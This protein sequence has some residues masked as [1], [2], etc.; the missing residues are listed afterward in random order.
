MPANDCLG[1]D[2]LKV[3]APVRK[4][5]PDQNP[6]EPVMPLEQ[7]A[8]PRAQRH[9]ELL[10]EQQVLQDEVV[11]TPDRR[12]TRTDDQQEESSTVAR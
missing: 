5:S 7:E 8:A 10:A 12:S 3:A 1:P 4:D 11:A 9:L 6:E 2:K